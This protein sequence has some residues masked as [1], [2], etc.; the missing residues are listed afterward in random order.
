MNRRAHRIGTIAL[1]VLALV[2]GMTATVAAKDKRDLTVMTQNL[3]VGA[4]V[5]P[6]SAA[7]TPFEFILAVATVYSEVQFTD[8]PA[9][10][11]AI[12]A[13]IEANAPDVIALQEV[14][15]WTSTGPGAPPSLD[16]LAI[17]QQDLADRGLSYSLAAA[18]NNVHVGPV[19]LLLCSGPFGSCFL[20]LQDRDVILVNDN[21]PSLQTSHPQSG[22]YVAQQVQQTPL[23]RCPSTAGGPRSTAR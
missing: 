23:A 6:V 3:Y 7:T 22:R 12:A 20:S 10:A 16:F 8:F 15:T 1:L 21:S 11:D 19:P 17:L 9:R 5:A 18:S 4:S 14:T 2:A 13:E